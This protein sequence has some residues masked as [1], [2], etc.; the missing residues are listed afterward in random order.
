MTIPESVKLVYCY[1]GNGIALGVY[2]SRENI[3]ITLNGL[4]NY[5][6][7]SDSET[8]YLSDNFGYVLTTKKQLLHG[9]ANMIVT[10]L[11]QKKLG[12]PREARRGIWE[13]AEA[14]SKVIFD[15]IKPEQ[16]LTSGSPAV[17]YEIASQTKF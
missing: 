15:N 16:F 4:F 6:A 5:G 9:I 10:D 13:Q 17:Q 11:T 14:E 8:R 7:H 2:G 12:E 3:D 1:F